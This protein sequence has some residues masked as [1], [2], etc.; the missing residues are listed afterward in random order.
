MFTHTVIQKK[1]S[2]AMLTHPPHF[3]I[4]CVRFYN[5]EDKHGRLEQEAD[6]WAYENHWLRCKHRRHV[7][8]QSVT[9]GVHKRPILAQLTL[10]KTVVAY[11]LPVLLIGI[12]VKRIITYIC[13]ERS[14]PARTD[15][16][17][18]TNI[19]WADKVFS[20]KLE[21]HLDRLAKGEPD[22]EICGTR[23]GFCTWWMVKLSN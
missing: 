12:T 18:I 4:V 17:E 7:S 19:L 2:N 14:A 10:V 15:G 23:N 22:T 13:I 5:C 6:S 1:L 9:L 3:C 11:G 8:S 16:I 21:P 20:F